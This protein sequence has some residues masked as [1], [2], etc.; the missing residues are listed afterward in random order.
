MGQLSDKAV[1]RVS[2][3]SWEPLRAAFL[4]I[5]NKLLDVS[6]DAV[7]ELTT[8]YVK[9]QVNT[10]P[11]A[12]VFAV[13]WLKTSKQIVVGLALPADYESSELGP[14][15]AG[16]KYKGITKYFRVEPGGTVPSELPEWAKLAYQ[17]TLSGDE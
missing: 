3:A 4:D 5:S 6:P 17:A 15:P 11:Q 2:G 16:M 13:A 1:E 12:K 10:S 7:G 8:I 14:A 9:Y